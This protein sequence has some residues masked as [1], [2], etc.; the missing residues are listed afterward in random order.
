MSV[1]L[2]NVTSLVTTVATALGVTIAGFGLSTSRK[3]LKGTTE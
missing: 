1:F 3:Q 2:S